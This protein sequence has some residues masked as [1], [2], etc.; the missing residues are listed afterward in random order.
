MRADLPGAIAGAIEE[1]TR[2]ALVFD[3][4][5]IAA[6]LRELA[7]AARAHGVTALFAAKSFPHPEVWAIAAELCDGF[8]AASAGEIAA[9]PAARVLSIVDPTGRALDDVGDAHVGA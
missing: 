8:D 1:L 4:A 3:R 5:R 9:L 2:P 6:N 7:A